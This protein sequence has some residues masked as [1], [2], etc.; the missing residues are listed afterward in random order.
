LC[1]FFAPDD[2]PHALVRADATAL[3]E[4]LGSM[5]ADDLAWD[6]ALAIVRRYALL[7]VGGD[8]LAMHRLVQ[9]VTRAHLSPEQRMA[10]ARAAV[11]RVGKTFPAEVFDPQTWATCARLLPH[12]VVALTHLDATYTEPAVTIHLWNAIGV[13]LY[14]RGQWEE[15]TP[16]LE[17]ALAISEA[18]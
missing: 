13:Y 9:A 14:A 16:Y 15:A 4:A 5:V 1:A 18:V 8:T 11:E 17:R 3:P 12:A 7:E 2:M 10:W 6:E